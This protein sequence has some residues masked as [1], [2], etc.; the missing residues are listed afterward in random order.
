MEGSRKKEGR[1]VWECCLGIERKW[2]WGR[3][4]RERREGTAG[5]A[6]TITVL[7]LK[8]HHRPGCKELS[9]PDLEFC[10]LPPLMFVSIYLER[11]SS[12]FQNIRC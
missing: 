12:R 5:K 1:K 3:E 7:I 10:I 6:C 11:Q 2:R 8:V 4:K 9:G